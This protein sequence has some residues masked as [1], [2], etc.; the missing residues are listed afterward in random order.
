MKKV[1]V[2]SLFAIGSMCMKAQSYLG[3]LTDNYSGIHGVVANPA[4]I[5]DSRFKTDINLVGLSVLGTNDYYGINVLDA[6]KDGY[7]F[8]LNAVKT[9]LEHNNIVVNTDILGPSFMFNMGKKSALA[10]FT[11]LRAFANINDIN[12]DSIDNLEDDLDANDDFSINEGDFFVAGNAWTEYGISYASVFMNKGKHFLKGGFSLKYL[13]GLGSVYSYG[14]DVAVNFEAKGTSLGGGLFTTGS[15]DSSGRITYGHFDDVETDNYKY[16]Q[17]KNATG[18]GADLGF[19]YEWRPKYATFSSTS[20]DGET[21]MQKDKNKYKLKLGLSITD[22]GYIN[23]GDG[24]ER[25]YDITNN[26]D[27]DSIVNED[28]FQDILDNLY[29]EIDSKN[30]IKAALP[31]AFHLNADWNF[32]NLLYLNVNMDF[33]V[34]S[35]SAGNASSVANVVSITP[36]YESKWFSFYVPLSSIQYSGFQV[37]AGLRMGPLYFGSGSI[38]SILG[39]DTT[40]SADVYAGV[41]IPIYESGSKNKNDVS[42]N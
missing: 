42:L 40:K 26:V 24:M 28:S 41:K 10:V 2:T 13:Q 25:T 31:T 37:G 8:D 29:R 5:V 38:V 16:E 32:N 30:T 27:E 35:K 22:I 19:T 9:P 4:S 1:I 12:G 34:V 11:R 6:I 14:K 33:A 20:A 39:S 21:N 3:Y 23:Y 36:R 7:D 17:P 15:L 18:F